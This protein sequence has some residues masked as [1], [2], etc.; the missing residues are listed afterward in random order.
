MKPVRPSTAICQRPGT[1]CRFIPVAMKAKI[2]MSATS[3]HS[4]LLVKLMS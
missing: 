4:E 2:S 3:I 1:S